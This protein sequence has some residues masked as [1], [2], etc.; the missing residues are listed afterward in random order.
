M[1]TSLTALLGLALLLG[2]AT[3]ARADAIDGKWCN[4]AKSIA[5][6]GPPITLP[7]GKVNS[8]P[9]RNDQ[10]PRSTRVD[11]WLCN[12]THSGPPSTAGW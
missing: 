4:G 11:I 3:A 12:S 7:S 9:P 5:I 2:V 1:R 6:D 8:I 10:F